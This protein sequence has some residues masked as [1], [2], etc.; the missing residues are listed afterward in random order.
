MTTTDPRGFLMRF[1][2]GPLAGK[3]NLPA[4]D[5]TMTTF[6]VSSDVWDWP[7]PDRLAILAHPQETDNVAMWDADGDGM[8]LPAL[9]WKSPNAVVY[10]K[11]SESQLPRGTDRVV[12]GAEYRL[13]Q[14]PRAKG[15]IGHVP[16]SK[17]V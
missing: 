8:G 9:I 6:N 13:E 10:R 14:P 2:D 17:S 16:Q 3:G 12:R 15:I 4:I 1:H 11:L 7:L 5:G